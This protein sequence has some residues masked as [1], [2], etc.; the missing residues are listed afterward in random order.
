MRPFVTIA[1]I[2]IIFL[3]V[4]IAGASEVALTT[5]QSEYYFPTGREAVIPFTIVSTYDH[6]I[7]GTLTRT[8]ILMGPENGGAQTAGVHSQAFSAFTEMRTVSLPV[9]TSDVPAEYLLTISFDYQEGGDRRSSLG[10]IAVHFVMDAGNTGNNQDTLVST[11]NGITSA[12][13]P[14]G[15]PAPATKSPDQDLQARLQNN[16]MPQDIALLKN[17][18]GQERN[19]SGS[20]TDS[21]RA[22]VLSDPIV[23]SINQTLAGAGF[24]LENADFRPVSASSGS[25]TLTYKSGTKTVQVSGPV[26]DT[27]V[28]FAEEISNSAVPLPQPLEDNTTFRQ[29]GNS[30]AEAGFT[31]SRTRIN[32][33]PGW[34]TINLS[35]TN[36]GGRI[37]RFNAQVE[38][39]TVVAAEGESPEDPL[40]PILPVISFGAILLI[41]AGIWYLA[42]THNGGVP[43][44]APL[45]P[46]PEPQESYRKIASRLLD[47]AEREAAGGSWPEAYRKTGRAV[48]VFVSHERGDGRETTSTEVERFVRPSAD[49][50]GIGYILE[51]CRIVGFARG[52]PNP[53]ELRKMIKDIRVLLKEELVA[54]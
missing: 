29:Y 54:G 39:G 34:D 2:F 13:A 22:Y 27:R 35:Y 6:D 14:S 31:V 52:T 24:S 51:R 45:P 53:A 40:A 28:G 33:T 3:C 21:L 12:G 36:Q 49:S 7:T 10:G 17:T 46:G 18:L 19:V 1:G 41:S 9:G 50:A 20:D 38:G 32:V 43:L 30:M 15:S 47:E 5:P 25:F 26:Q 37:V 4:P 42:R 11:D 16:Q 44:P 48:R 8:E 23:L